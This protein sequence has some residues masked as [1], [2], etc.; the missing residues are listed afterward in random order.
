LASF[1]HRVFTPRSVLFDGCLVGVG[2]LLTYLKIYFSRVSWH[3][4]LTMFLLPTLHC[5]SPKSLLKET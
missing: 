4:F 5:L 3:H 1:P 2:R